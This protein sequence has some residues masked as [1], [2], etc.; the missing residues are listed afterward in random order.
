MYVTV[1]LLMGEV[2]TDAT[3][4]YWFKDQVSKKRILVLYHIIGRFHCQAICL[5]KISWI[6]LRSYG[7]NRSRSEKIEQTL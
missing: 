1:Q 5:G 4:G 3:A 2:Y 6:Y 7:K